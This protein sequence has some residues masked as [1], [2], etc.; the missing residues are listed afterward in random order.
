MAINNKK[1]KDEVFKFSNSN[2]VK[3]LS[4]Q[5]NK[6]EKQRDKA[7]GEA[8]TTERSLSG[9]LILLTTVLIT[10]NVVVLSGG[11][12]L[13]ENLSDF[14]KLLVLGAFLLETTAI[15]AGI[16][17]YFKVEGSYN[18]WADAYHDVV[19]II[20]SRSYST[21]KELSDKVDK[22]QKLDIRPPRQVLK[23]QVICIIASFIIYFTLIVTFFYDLSAL[24]ATLL[25]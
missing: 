15:I 11:S 10:V 24:K 6:F 18:K 7:S 9:Q 5:Q 3:Y 21:E 16:A 19:E 13:A 2:T 22:A 23:V 14:Q 12:N 17:H 4:E 8:N 25:C 1:T 20:V